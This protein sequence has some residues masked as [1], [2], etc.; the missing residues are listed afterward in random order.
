MFSLSQCT[1]TTAIGASGCRG[2]KPLTSQVE[3]NSLP[4]TFDDSQQNLQTKTKMA[5]HMMFGIIFLPLFGREL[6]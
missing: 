6:L 2:K 1:E 3:Y 5:H 4:Y